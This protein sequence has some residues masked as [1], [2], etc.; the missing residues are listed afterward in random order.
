MMSMDLRKSLVNKE[1]KQFCVEHQCQLLSIPKSTY[2][3]R[4]IGIKEEDLQIMRMMDELYIEDP[5]RGTRRYAG[6]ISKLGYHLGRDHARTLMQIMG[7]AAI[8]PK[9]R[10]TVIDKTKYKFPYLLRGININAPNV[11]WG[12]DIS[13]IPMRYGFMYL[14][15][16]IDIYSKFIVGWSISNTMD[17]SWVVETLKEAVHQ[18]GA[19]KYINSDQ[20]TQFT[21]NEYVDYVKSL[22][23]TQISMDGKGRATDNAHIERF[24][25]TIKYDKL[26]LEPS[27]DGNILYK[28]CHEFITYYNNKRGHSTHKYEVPSTIYQNVA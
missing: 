2:Y 20:G 11:A 7:I 5:T 9:P 6:E 16:I 15:A 13:Y 17:A 21:S 23:N 14:F 28:Q 26:Y 4:P 24:F 27:K 25:R 1:D 3:Y 18:H 22:P 10:T 12:I 8:Y 19:P